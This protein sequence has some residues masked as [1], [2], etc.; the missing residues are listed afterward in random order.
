M[1]IATVVTQSYLP[2]ARVLARSFLAHNP[3]GRVVVLV[4]DGPGEGVRDDDPFDVVTVDQLLIEPRELRRMA[5]IYS[6]VELATALKPFLLRYLVVD[7]GED[8]AAY[9]DSDIEVFGP[10]DHLREAA[11][12][13]SLVVTPHRLGP[14]TEGVPPIEFVWARSGSYNAGFVAVSSAA[15]PFLD[16][17]SERCRRDC[18]DAVAEGFFVDQRWLDLAVSY[19]PHHVVRDPGCNV[20]YWNL[21]E[22]PLTHAGEVGESSWEVG[23]VPLRFF[24]FSGFDPDVPHMLT[25]YQGPR[26][27][28]LL[29]QEPALRTLCAGYAARLEEEGRSEYRKFGYGFAR[30]ANGMRIDQTMRRV[31]RR[32]LLLREEGDRDY[33]GGADDL[34]DPFEPAEVAEFVELLRSPFPGSD[35][36]RIQRYLHGLYQERPDLQRSFPNLGGDGG[37]HFLWWVREMG[38]GELGIPPEMVPS[39]EDLDPTEPASDVEG[40]GGELVAGVRLVGYLAADSGVGELGRSA[41]AALLAVGELFG[42]LLE[43]DT[44]SP[45]RSAVD[46]GGAVDLGS[47]VGGGSGIRASRP[48]VGGDVNLVCVDP[49]RF[50]LVMDRLGVRFRQNRYTIGFWS[51]DVEDLPPELATAAQ[52]LDEV[53]ATSQH[54]AGA[55]HRAFEANDID[56]PVHVVAPPVRASAA[57]GGRGRSELG[58]PDGFLFLS[59]VDMLGVVERKNPLGV[60]EAFCRAFAPGEGPQ[61]VLH[62]MNG[63]TQIPELERL[64]FRALDRPDIHIRDGYLDPGDHQACLAASDAY[65]SLHRA[66]G[67]GYGMAEAMLMGKP[68]VATGYSGNLEFMDEQNSY[69]VGYEMTPIGVGRWPYPAGSRWADPD[70]DAAA[71]ILRRI[72]EDPAAAQA[73]G[74]RARHDMQARYS[75][76]ARGAVFAERLAA[77]RAAIAATQV[78]AAEAVPTPPQRPRWRRLRPRAGEEG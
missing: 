33:L 67:F 18:I 16:W 28:V 26:P 3:A 20:A 42:V 50:P 47:A 51:W 35:A 22:R 15:V 76:A 72:V 24:H 29:S 23:G 36:P 56:R 27:W 12:K 38:Q 39:V 25:P 65:V 1:L 31:F 64:R 46:V 5:A 43:R 63:S 61:L 41:V 11:E 53:W 49:A 32:E 66:E 57:S 13:H 4:F 70:L 60:I 2:Q 62:S 6:V 40:A 37:N 74:E 44:P 55:I 71:A 52:L 7:R 8:C 30:A 77:S 10:L 45:Q 14:L 73:V 69:L 58:L 59:C 34:P 75:P 68:V 19:F 54:A 48:D 17:W 78:V 9:V 21:D